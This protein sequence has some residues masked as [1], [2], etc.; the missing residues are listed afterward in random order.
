MWNIVTSSEIDENMVK[1]IGLFSSKWLRHRSQN[2]IDMGVGVPP[3]GMHLACIRIYLENRKKKHLPMSQGVRQ[4]SGF[5][6]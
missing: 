2:L 4:K 5:R 1:D 6:R 3:A